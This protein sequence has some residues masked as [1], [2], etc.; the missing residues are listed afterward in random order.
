MRT[1][2]AAL[3]IGLTLAVAAGC[4]GGAEAESGGDGNALLTAYER[5]NATSPAMEEE[6][7][8]FVASQEG[9]AA[10]GKVKLAP[11]SAI[12]LGSMVEGKKASEELIEKIREH[13]LARYREAG[14]ILPP[15]RVQI[16]IR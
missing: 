14:L 15:D 9:V 11:T 13:V 10:A 6:I 3:L 8:I 5:F 1:T 2:T 4:K 7:R 12:V 16:M